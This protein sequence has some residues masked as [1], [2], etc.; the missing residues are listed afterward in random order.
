[1]H[2]PLTNRDPFPIK[3][4]ENYLPILDT[5]EEKMRNDFLV[6]FEIRNKEKAELEKKNNEKIKFEEEKK[7]FQQNQG[8]YDMTSTDDG[9]LLLIKKPVIESFPITTTQCKYNLDNST[10]NVPE[11]SEDSRTYPNHFRQT[12]ESFI[13]FECAKS[14]QEMNSLKSKK[15]NQSVSNFELMNPSSGVTIIEKGV[16]K[17]SGIEHLENVNRASRKIFMKKIVHNN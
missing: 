14:S 2:L 6:L 4:G 5:E 15:F 11:I 13:S 3:Y 10:V 17:K 7:I 16:T 9:H 1:M 12:M 8:F